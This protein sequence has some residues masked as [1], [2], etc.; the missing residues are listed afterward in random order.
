[1]INN[2]S[3]NALNLSKRLHAPLDGH[4]SSGFSSNRPRTRVL[5]PLAVQTRSP[6]LVLLDRRFPS[7]AEYTEKIGLKPCLFSQVRISSLRRRF[8]MM[9]TE[10]DS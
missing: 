6:S 7:S 1:M 9:R 4:F 2:L 3:F 5:H 8:L 10:V